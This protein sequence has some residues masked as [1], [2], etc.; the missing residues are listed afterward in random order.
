MNCKTISSILSFFFLS[1]TFNAQNLPIPGGVP[2]AEVWY[3]ANEQDL[4]VGHFENH[5]F[6][7]IELDSCGSFEPR[8]FN[9]N[10]SIYSDNLCISYRAPLES[11]STKNIFMVSAP[12]DTQYS[13][14]HISTKFNDFVPEPFYSDSLSRNTYTIETKKGH[15]SKLNATFDQHQNA[16]VYFYSWNNYDIDKK[17]KS[18][19]QIGE[20]LFTLGRFSS[21]SE[22]HIS[23][24]K[25]LFP[26]YV[27]FDRQ[28]TANEQN[29][30]ESYLALKYGITQWNTDS[31]LNSKNKV[32]WDKTNNDLF[33]KNIFGIG[34]D[35]VS[36]L[37]QLQG[38]SAHYRD[39]LVAA[40]HEIMD[41]NAEVQASHEIENDDFLVFGDTGGTGLTLMEGTPLHRL[42][43]IWLAQATGD[44]IRQIPIAFRV[45]VNNE[46]QPHISDLV[47]GNLKLWMLHDPYANNGDISDFDNGNIEYHEL[48]YIPPGGGPTLQF[49]HFGVD[50][51]IFDQDNSFFDQFTFAVGPECIAQ[52]RPRY[53]CDAAETGTVACY[54]LD[55]ILTG[56][57]VGEA[58]L[59]L[60]DGEMANVPIW[61]NEEQ[62]ALNGLITYTAS[63]C[64]PMTYTL[65]ITPD[66]GG[67]LEYEY[68]AG[69]IGP[70]IVDLGPDPQYLSTLQPTILLDA[71]QYMNDPGTTFQWF[72]NGEQ[73]YHY[74]GT[75][76]VDQPGEYCVVVTTPDGICE[77][78]RCVTV[79][80]SLEA[81]I[82]C[83]S[84]YCDVSANQ[85]EI[86]IVSGT[87]PYTTVVENEGGQSVT[88]VHTGNTVIEGLSN[89]EH[90]ITITDSFGAVHE[91]FCDFEPGSDGTPISMGPDLTLSPSN[92]Q[93]TLDASSLWGGP[94]N[95]LYE[96]LYNGELMPNTGPQLVVD[97]PGEYTAQV[98]FPDS[99]CYG[100]AIQIVHSILEGSIT[101]SGECDNVLHIEIDFGFPDYVTTIEGI[102]GTVYS[103]TIMH[104]GNINHS[105]IPFGN[106]EIT[107][108]DVFGNQI[109]EQVEFI[110]LES[111]L[112]A[113][114]AG[115]C[116]ICDE[117]CKIVD[118]YCDSNLTAYFF[119][120][121]LATMSFDASTLIDGGQSVVYDWSINGIELNYTDP[122]LEF[123]PTGACNTIY[124]DLPNYCIGLFITVNITD[125][126]SGCTL[127][128]T[129]ITNLNWCPVLTP[130][131]PFGY[132]TI[133]YPNPS[134]SDVTF[135]YNIRSITEATFEGRVEVFS[136]LGSLIHSTPINGDSE[137][138]LPYQLVTAGVYLIRTTINDGTVTVDRVIIK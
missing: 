70:Y 61:L 23:A 94:S 10:P 14:P 63:V 69:V 59:Q 137:Y 134:E 71:G 38:E 17:F 117:R 126:E 12:K 18:Y 15:A 108:T 43:K 74:E 34:R 39:F 123:E 122:V 40:I 53:S 58:P 89:G 82:V 54:E 30:V 24:F 7:D 102:L 13:Y 104:T 90:T 109:Q 76:L 110:G 68:E 55:I 120:A 22:P 87:P 31:Y 93:Y 119:G 32:F 75:L 57:C 107:V 95:Y 28:L 45:L 11:S 101:P 124:E 97:T 125:T 48:S 114:L 25:G 3:I 67:T 16:H 29:R 36:G 56:K 115:Y 20:T 51:I 26:E 131:A 130:P 86:T 5:A 96:W 91:G 4:S 2:G 42:N 52:F 21:P 127:S 49:P 98:Y 9:F 100:Y 92:P 128:E 35:D 77:I 79:V 106:F 78:E 135:F 132:K 85:I 88:Y 37:N 1:L 113:Q 111:N 62:T 65:V 105:G 81:V 73:I 129:I 83:H 66:S 60:L 8:L 138:T 46:F 112:E 33:P 136:V 44:S 80:A 103:E 133:I 64:A 6:N 118:N 47:N 84:G 50:E 121:C 99:G 27:T 19:G 72:F 41:T 116:D